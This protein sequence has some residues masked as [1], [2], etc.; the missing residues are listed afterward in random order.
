VLTVSNSSS[1]GTQTGD[2]NAGFLD[3]IFWG[4]ES[5]SDEASISMQGNTVFNV[6]LDHSILKQQNY[7]A[8]IDSNFLW[9][10]TDPQF[11]ATG[12]P[13]N[14]FDFHV[15][16]G[17]PAVDRGSNLGIT[18]DLDGNPRPVNLPDLGCYER[19]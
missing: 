17:S 12:Y 5:I 1:D 3:C 15:E 18:I 11:L 6:L 4:S 7:P 10:N 16:A 9:L 2:L 8:N 19:Q 13:G 14:T